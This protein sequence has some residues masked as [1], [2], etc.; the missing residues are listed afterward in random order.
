MIIGIH[1]FNIIYIKTSY[2]LIWV[3]FIEIGFF[4]NVYIR[5][6]LPW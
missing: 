4:K 1:H 6:Q 5:L 2:K 3:Y